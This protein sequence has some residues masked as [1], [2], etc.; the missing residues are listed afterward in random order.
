ML[1]SPRT[2]AASAQANNSRPW[3]LRAQCVEVQV[4]ARQDPA[5]GAE[6]ELGRLSARAFYHI[7]GQLT[8]LR[9]EQFEVRRNAGTRGVRLQLRQHV[10]VSH[11]DPAG[12]AR[13]A[14]IADQRRPALPVPL[15]EPTMELEFRDP[16]VALDAL[17]RMRRSVAHAAPATGSWVPCST[18][19]RPEAAAQ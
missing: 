19:T 2:G 12:H 9:T 1:R 13:H 10:A 6:R 7:P 15:L 4:E 14:R 16:G 5:L 11:E 3:R 18:G 17:H 8:G